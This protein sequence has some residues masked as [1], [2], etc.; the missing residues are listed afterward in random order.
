MFRTMNDEAT[1]TE[2]PPRSHSPVDSVK[3]SAGRIATAVSETVGDGMR[4]IRRRARHGQDVVEDVRD[5]LRLHVRR[6]PLQALGMAFA[7][8]ATAALVAALSTRALL[9]R[10]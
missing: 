4:G 2:S 5:G 10:R 8:G 3:Q 6:H 1:A 7:V 9:R